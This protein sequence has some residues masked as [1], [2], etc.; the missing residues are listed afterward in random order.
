MNRSTI[1]WLE[2]LW[3]VAVKARANFK[4]ELSG[5]T[6]EVSHH[7]L[8]KPNLWLRFSLDNGIALTNWEHEYMAHKDEKAFQEKVKFLRG[9]HSLVKLDMDF[10]WK[11]ELINLDKTYE[12]LIEEICKRLPELDKWIEERDIKSPDFKSKYKRLY[13]EI[14]TRDFMPSSYS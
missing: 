2:F 11:R 8:H 13:N 7:I 14:R 10:R 9:E 4:S 6:C 5:I 3:H 1:N 12:I